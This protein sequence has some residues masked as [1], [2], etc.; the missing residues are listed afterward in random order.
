MLMSFVATGQLVLENFGI[1]PISSC[2][3][4][5]IS[6]ILG[7]GGQTCLKVAACKLSGL[8]CTAGRQVWVPVED[9]QGG[10]GREGAVHMWGQ[11]V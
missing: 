1:D 10:G 6:F 4:S 8:R 9:Q 3:D 5:D 7:L 2:C 11:G